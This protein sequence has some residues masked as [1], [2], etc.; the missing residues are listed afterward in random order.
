MKVCPECERQFTGTDWRC[1]SCG[2]HAER[3]RG[4]V[5]VLPPSYEVEGFPG[6]QF[7]LHAA[8][9]ERYFWHTARNALIGW[10]LAEYIPH[11]K[12]FLEAGCG[13]GQVLAHLRRTRPHLQLTGC[14][15]LL[16]GLR[17]AAERV[18]GIALV[19]ADIRH[20]PFEEEFDAVGAF[21]VLEHVV[22]HED[23]LRQ[24]IRAVRPGGGIILTVPQHPE[25]WAPRD[26]FWGHQRRYTRRQLVEL[27]RKA[28]LRIE[29][30]TSF[31]SLLLPAMAIA[32]ITQ[33]GRPVSLEREYAISPVHNS[34]CAGVMTTERA[35]IR[36]GLSFPAGGS[37]LAVTSRP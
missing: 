14:E 23:A 13:T 2:W 28:G 36:A 29:R 5:H 20:L 12:S 7:E 9:T 35:L 15:A 27:L 25:L 16:D 26:D 10:A 34:L 4:I 8:L 30:V 37:L 18:P 6:G 21:D 22:E 3:S 11:A 33:R 24:L 19:Q 32:R 1:A 31:V 17:I